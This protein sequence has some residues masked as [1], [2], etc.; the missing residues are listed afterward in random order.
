M[1]LRTPRASEGPLDPTG[2]HGVEELGKFEKKKNQ[3]ALVNGGDWANGPRSIL[4]RGRA[5]GTT[6][7]PCTLKIP[8]II[9]NNLKI[10][11]GKKWNH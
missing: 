3:W 11:S 9:K 6:D 5:L 2:T 4:V 7:N 10:G 1:A 8:Q